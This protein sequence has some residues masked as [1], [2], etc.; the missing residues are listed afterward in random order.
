MRIKYK[1]KPRF[2]RNFL[3]HLGFKKQEHSKMNCQKIK[4]LVPDYLDDRLAPHEGLQVEAH[5]QTC[6]NCRQEVR[7]ME[8]SWQMLGEVAEIEPDPHYLTRFW[9]RVDDQ[10][11]WYEKVLQPTREMFFQ[12]RWVPALAA[13]C[14]ILVV[15]GVSIRN[16]LMV[17]AADTVVGSLRAIDLEMVEYIDIIENFDLIQDIEFYS[18]LEI[19]E[20]L[21][22]LEAS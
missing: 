14:V 8:K 17:P 13:A 22:G 18:D 12:R 19:I 4:Q 20:E 16:H 21:N 10:K 2:L 11:K 15:A 6:S 5:L 9:A 7:L 3:A 1:S